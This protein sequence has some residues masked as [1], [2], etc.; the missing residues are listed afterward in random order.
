MMLA[1]ERRNRILTKLTLTGKV[2]VS[3]LS[4]EFGV[5]EET[6]RRDLEKLD[7][8]GLAHKTYGGAV[9]AKRDLLDLP[10]N[11]RKNVSVTEKQQIAALCAEKVKDGSIIML[12]SSS[13]AIFIVK[14]LKSRQN[15]TVITNSV[16]ILLE[17]SDMKGWNVIST[18]GSL[19]EGALALVGPAALH[20]IANY[21]ADISICS[22][23]GID[24]DFGISESND[25]DAEIKRVMLSS[26][27]EKILALDS[28]KFDKRSF[29]R[30]CPIRNID[31]LITDK[32]PDEKWL[33]VLKESSFDVIY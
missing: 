32:A 15:L 6:I 18:G 14:Q 28:T 21:H 5:T 17:L 1:A 8:E 9:S 12:D 4:E 10:L 2:I 3:E 16:E 23:K 13:T 25:A 26:A 30:V 24:V 33:S 22:A 27:S 7:E 29:V 19:K 11:V 31:L 20:T